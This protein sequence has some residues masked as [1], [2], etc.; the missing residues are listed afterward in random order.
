MH[1]FTYAGLALTGIDRFGTEWVVE[2]VQGWTDGVGVRSAREVR[3]GQDGEWDSTPLRSAREVTWTGK[4]LAPDHA[5]LEQSARGF[6]AVPARG[7]AT[8]A[9]EG[10][11]LSALAR[12]ADAPRF[13][14]STGDTGVWQLTVVA[15]DP[16]LYGPAVVLSTNLAGASG[17][18]RVWARVWPRDWGVP[19]G[20]TPGSLPAP[21][22]GTAPYWPT[23]RI[24]G[25][26]TNPVITLNESGDWVRI[27]R[28]ISAG[29]WLDIDFANRR[30][31]LN[32]L[33]SLAGNV[34]FSGRWLAVPV[35]GG[36]ISWV[37]DTADPA[38]LLTINAFEGAF[39]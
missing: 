13:A 18:G 23:A 17:T 30:V 28:T 4:A 19:A 16:L 22:A 21:N 27:N 9:S 38:A 1:E 31:M 14:H 3:A 29:Q 20:T 12:L 32:G 7:E 10:L 8:G 34:T 24:D 2:S 11:I 33:V 6:A 15:P 39:L 5:A 35:G 26:V 25:P 37:A 36:S